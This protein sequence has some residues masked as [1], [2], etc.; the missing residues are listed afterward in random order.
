MFLTETDLINRKITDDGAMMTSEMIASLIQEDLRSP[1]KRRMMEGESYYA[2]E[3]DI[4]RK[5][6][7]SET[8]SEVN[9]ATGENY[10]TSFHNPNR[11]NQHTVNPFHR[12]LVDQKTAYMVGKEPTITVK[13]AEENQSL[14]EYEKLVCGFADE[15]FNEVMADLIT[16]ASNKGLE[17][18][19]IYIDDTGSLQYCI[20]PATEIIPV[21]DTQY[22]KELEQVIR[23]YDIAVTRDGKKYLIKRVEWWTKKDVTYYTETEKGKYVLDAS[24]AFNPSPHWWDITRLDGYEKKRI[25]HSWGKVPFVLLK[26]NNRCISDLQNIKGLIDAY[27]LI[28]SEGTNSLLDLVDL[29]WCISGY[30]G[31]TAAAI[32][33]KLRINK[34][35]NVSGAGDGN[36]EAKQV[37]L[38]VTGR[39]EWLKM[40]RRDIYQFGMGIDV[41]ADKFGNAPSGVSLK[42]QYGLLDMKANAMAAKV[43]KVI[44]ELLW[45]FIQ[46][47]NRRS[48]TNYDSSLIEVSLN[49]SAVANDQETVSMITAS[50]GIVSRKTLLAKHPFIT[51]VNAE[52]QTLEEEISKEENDYTGFPGGE[53]RNEE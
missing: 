13:G 16:G 36:I 8:I 6:F 24:P 15:D 31:E 44:K 10:E 32:A 30:G 19:H 20:V 49:Y 45:Y 40:L 42:F 21:Y 5:D 26:N 41:D 39:L 48:N 25:P 2:G 47:Y 17:A 27:D 46:D 51:D 11:S 3:H 53:H 12:I 4:L 7:T 29:Y 1:Q 37:D 9:E 38:P 18:L 35:V 50:E 22:Q 43:K 14:K 23:Y 52:M 33:K 28:S 34:A